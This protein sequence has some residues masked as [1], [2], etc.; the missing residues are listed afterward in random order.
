VDRV[1]RI[2]EDF[3]A[4]RRDEAEFWIKM[5]PRFVLIRYYAMRDAAEPTAERLR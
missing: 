5:G 2:L 4:N 1:Q 3:R